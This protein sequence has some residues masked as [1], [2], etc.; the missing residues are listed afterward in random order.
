MHGHGQ[1]LSSRLNDVRDGRA[2]FMPSE[3]ANERTGL[4]RTGTALSR[5]G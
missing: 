2:M 4:E 3:R 5:L 1:I